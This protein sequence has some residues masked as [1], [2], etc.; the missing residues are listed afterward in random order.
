MLG[1]PKKKLLIVGAGGF[2]REVLSY[3]LD[4]PEE[5]RD[6]D[7]FG[8]LD[9]AP[10]ALANYDISVPLVG[11]I[12]GHHPQE[13]E[14]FVC[15]VGSPKMKQRICDKLVSQGAVFVSILHPLAYVGPRVVL[16]RGCIVA[17]HAML[18][19]DIV[20][21][22][23]VMLNC[24]S[25]CGHDVTID[26]YSTLSAHCDVTG[27]CRLAKGVF[28]GSHATIMPEKNVGEFAVIGAGAVVVR[29]VPN[30]V[31]VYGNPAVRLK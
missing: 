29:N 1:L 16:G 15:A 25:G 12:D 21:G 30:G 2:G 11:S 20:L 18:T 3:A 23:F 8:F 13:D 28:M 26:S 6:W 27:F 4:I 24:Y 17:P 10:E 7:V 14:V 9:D 22:D 19:C 5:G 31:T